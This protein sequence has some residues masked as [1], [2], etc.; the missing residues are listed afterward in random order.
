MFLNFVDPVLLLKKR[1]FFHLDLGNLITNRY[2]FLILPRYN[3]RQY[4]GCSMIDVTLKDGVEKTLIENVP[5]ITGIID[6]TDHS[7]TENAYFK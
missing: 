5:E 1:I 4:Q 2:F 7:H 3:S 6:S